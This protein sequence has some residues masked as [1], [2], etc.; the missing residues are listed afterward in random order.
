MPHAGLEHVQA[1]DHVHS[2]VE[3]RVT[4][5]RGHAHLGRLVVDHLG[6]ELREDP[7]HGVRVAN[8]RL[9][10][11]D[12]VCDVLALARAQVVE[13]RDLVAGLDEG[14]HNVTTDETGS[15]GDQDSHLPSS[16]WVTHS[17]GSTGRAW[18]SVGMLPKASS[19]SKSISSW[20]GGNM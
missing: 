20:P 18:G 8:V 7:L 16:I 2:G 9:G 1:A 15:A 10:E 11:G 12:P 3:L 19:A 4:R 5:A 14:V 17:A 6:T 13:D